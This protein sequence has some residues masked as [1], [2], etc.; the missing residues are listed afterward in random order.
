MRA[1]VPGQDDEAWLA[2]NAAAF[3]DHPDQG[4]VTLEDLK[5]K[6]K[7]PWFEPAGFLLHEDTEGGEATGLLLDEG[8][9]RAPAAPRGGA[10]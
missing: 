9:R 10:M 2:V 7:E 8:A 3:A 6:Q 1:F 5:A 4:Q